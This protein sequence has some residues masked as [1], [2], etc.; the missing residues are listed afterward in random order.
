MKHKKKTIESVFVDVRD[1]SANGFVESADWQ[2]NLMGEIR[3]EAV[4]CDVTSGEIADSTVWAFAGSFLALAVLVL[5]VTVGM[6]DDTV[7][8]ELYEDSVS[9]EYS[10]IEF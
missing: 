9:Y 5:A 10:F 1:H 4:R 7:E 3:R 8:F 6:F 2:A